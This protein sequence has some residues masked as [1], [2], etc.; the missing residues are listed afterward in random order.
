MRE[1]NQ[2]F[3]P[4]SIF[5]ALG[6]AYTGARGKTARE[7]AQVLH[8]PPDLMQWPLD[9]SALNR[10]LERE[11]NMEGQE[12]CV[13]NT[14]W[15]QKGLQLLKE[16][17]RFSTETFGATP[18]EADF[19]NQTETARQ[20]INRWVENETHERIKDLIPNGGID[21]QTR[22]VLANAVYFKGIWEEPFEHSATKPWAFT[23]FDGQSVM[24]PMMQMM[25]PQIARYA[26]ATDWQVLELPY[27]GNALS[28]VFIL[29]RKSPENTAPPTSAEFAAFEQS[30]TPMKL[31]SLLARLQL[32]DVDTTL[33][34]FTLLSPSLTLKEVLSSLGL[35]TAFS[36]Y[37]DFSGM[38]K[39]PLY[40]SEVFHKAFIAVA[41]EGT[42][43][44]AATSIVMQ[45]LA[46]ALPTKTVTFRADHPFV[47][48]IRHQTS[49]AIL[50]MGRVVNPSERT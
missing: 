27:K 11:G 40:F 35:R 10:E 2:V 33:P 45:K 37:A 50:F 32:A 20:T 6:R 9:L 1:G 31:Q 28:M 13:A 21:S 5:S 16:Y 36:Q 8:L 12:L 46:L 38:T 42:E 19:R 3:S 14:I 29:P 26:E 41:E 44:A 43:A 39:E 47:F 49:G 15:T 48:L 30:L 22:A 25:V 17:V 4:Y 7:M 34:K 23:L 18:K 24:T